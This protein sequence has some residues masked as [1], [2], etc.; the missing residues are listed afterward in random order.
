MGTYRLT[1]Y[2]SVVIKLFI[3]FIVFTPG[4]QLNTYVLL[5]SVISKHWTDLNAAG[6]LLLLIFG[7]SSQLI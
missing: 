4:T 5:I 2:S 3:G 7:M 6:W 1:A